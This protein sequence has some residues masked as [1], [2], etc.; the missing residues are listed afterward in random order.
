[1]S[2]S[3]KTMI[4]AT[5]DLLRPVMRFGLVGV[6]ATV[7][8]MVGFA[9]FIEIFHIWAV[10]A[11]VLAYC[12][13][14]LV[15]FTGHYGW[16]F[17]EQTRSPDVPWRRS[18]VR[19]LAVSMFGLILNTAQVALIVDILGLHYWVAIASMVVVTTS[20]VFLLSRFWAF[21]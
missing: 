4:A 17:R 2:D 10:A 5:L 3:T 7:V 8:H 14:F 15:S 6:A 18:V 16:S 1:M 21:R 20:A 11:N 12:V 13:A 19:F 9:L